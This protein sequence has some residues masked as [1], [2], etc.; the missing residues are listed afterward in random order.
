MV[1]GAIAVIQDCIKKFHIIFLIYYLF[2]NQTLLSATYT[3]TSGSLNI[4]HNCSNLNKISLSNTMICRIK[5]KSFL[6][7]QDL[8]DEFNVIP[9]NEVRT[10]R[11]AVEKFPVYKT[12]TIH[13]QS[14][15]FIH[16]P[17][18]PS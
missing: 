2:I 4:V 10:E 15:L 16:L 3:M 9:G 1:K 14:A 11:H 6:I 17:V 18:F 8:M 7:N 12:N 5:Q 13:L